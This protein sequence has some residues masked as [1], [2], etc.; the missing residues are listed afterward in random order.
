MSK[1]VSV[2]EDEDED[3][4]DDEKAEV[5]EDES[6]STVF[7]TK[8]SKREDN[9]SESNVNTP[10]IIVTTRAFRLMFFNIVKFKK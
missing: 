9:I 5:L 2:E 8:I 10:K 6:N 7:L 3:D 4:E 1:T